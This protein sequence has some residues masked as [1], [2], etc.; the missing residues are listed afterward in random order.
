MHFKMSSAK[1]ILFCLGLSVSFAH[2]F[3]KFI[4]TAWLFL[5][6]RNS[7]I[8]LIVVIWRQNYLKCSKGVAQ[9]VLKGRSYRAKQWRKSA[10]IKAADCHLYMAHAYNTTTSEARHMSRSDQ[11]MNPW[12]H[13][14]SRIYGQAMGC[15]FCTLWEKYDPE[16]P[17]T[18]FTNMDWL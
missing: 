6:P 8:T 11:T 3:A 4:I 15:L 18:L 13:A 2:I 12:C 14:I 1:W 9:N 17:W 16:I 7:F 5:C 10:C